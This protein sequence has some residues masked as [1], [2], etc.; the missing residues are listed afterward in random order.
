MQ[1]LFIPLDA[2][3]P[4]LVDINGIAAAPDGSAIYAIDVENGVA[5]RFGISDCPPVP[6]EP[7]TPPAPSPLVLEPTFTG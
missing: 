7:P 3:T 5:Y 1:T 2:A 6:P 4:P